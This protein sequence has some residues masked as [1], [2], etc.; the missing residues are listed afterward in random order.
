MA[1][2]SYVYL[3]WACREPD[4]GRRRRRRRRRRR[5]WRVARS[6]R[7]PSC[8]RLMTWP[9]GAWRSCVLTCNS[10]PSGTCALP[11][12]SELP[13]P[14]VDYFEP[15]RPLANRPSLNRRELKASCSSLYPA[16]RELQPK[17]K[18]PVHGRNSPRAVGIVRCWVGTKTRW[19]GLTWSHA[20]ARRCAGRRRSQRWRAACT[21]TTEIQ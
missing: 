21:R 15:L 11:T 14:R 4:P 18:K 6:Q 2:P 13:A 12:P 17:T 1:A 20:C 3:G 7:R 5:G 9:P 16:G 19:N 10:A 8:P